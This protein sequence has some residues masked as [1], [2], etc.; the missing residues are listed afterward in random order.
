MSV[1]FNFLHGQVA[2]S[3]NAHTDE[4]VSFLLTYYILKEG[5]ANK[6]LQPPGAKLLIDRSIS[7]AMK[8]P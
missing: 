1:I 6:L 4:G 5:M 7:C 3:E 8:F 2:D